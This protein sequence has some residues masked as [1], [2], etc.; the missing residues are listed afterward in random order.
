MS[1]SSDAD[2]ASGATT[3]AAISRAVGLDLAS[4]RRDHVDRQLDSVCRRERIDLTGLA[5]LAARDP[6]TAARVRRAIAVAVTGLFRDPDQFDFLA[7]HVLPRLAARGDRLRIWSAGCADGTELVSTALLLRDAG[8]LDRAFLLGSDV[9]RE[10][11]ALAQSLLLEHDDL[12]SRVRF[13][14]RDLLG[15]PPPGRFALVLCRN[16]LIYFEPAVKRAVQQRLA[17]TLAAGGAL[18]L[19]RS[20]RLAATSDLGLRHL[21]DHVYL[22]D[23]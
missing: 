3:L 19:G 5:E 6:D 18:M 10:N 22:R 7:A 14:V 4:Y 2:G 15:D 11:V 21:G 23:V 8:L 1:S 16:V 13:E 12:R 20:E 17:S 9:L